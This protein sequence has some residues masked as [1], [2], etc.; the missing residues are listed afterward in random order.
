MELKRRL[1]KTQ[2]IPEDDAWVRTHC[3]M[4]LNWCGTLV[5]RQKGNVI[6]IEGDPDNP[7]NR[8]KICAKGNSAF[9]QLYIPDRIITPLIRKNPEKGA[10][11][12][13][14]FEPIGWDDALDLIASK[15][16]KIRS[17]NPRKL[18][19]TS[20]D[21]PSMDFYVAWAQGFGSVAKPMAAD[22]FCGNAVHNIHLTNET[23]F[24]ADPDPEL[25]KYF[26]LVGAQFGSVS[27]YDVMNAVRGI[28]ER[29]PS[30]VKVV[31]VDP[32]AGYAGSKAEEWVPIRPGTDCAFLLSVTNLLVNDYNIYDANFLKRQTNAPYLI[33]K[34]GAY[35]RDN[36]TQKPLVW[37]SSQNQAVAFDTTKDDLALLGTYETEGIECQPAFQKLKDHLRKYSAEYSSEITTIPAETIKRIA[38]EFGENAS[39]GSTLS[40]GGVEMPYRPVC[41]AWYRG[42]SSHRHSMMGGMAAENLNVIVGAI[43]VPGG[44]VGSGRIP[45][46]VTIDGLM[47]PAGGIYPGA[48]PPR[49]VTLPQTPD[50]FS[51]FPVSS[52]SSSLNYLGCLQPEVYKIPFTYEMLIVLRTNIMKT[53]A[54]LSIVEQFMR[55]IPFTLAFARRIEETTGMAD[56]VL[57]DLHYLE[58]ISFGLWFRTGPIVRS[59]MIGYDHWYGQK[60]VVRAPMNS[61]WGDKFV[62]LDQVLLELARRADFLPD[63]YRALNRMWRLKEPYI[64]DPDAEYTFEEMVDRCLK[65]LLGEERGYKWFMT[66]GLYLRPRNPQE[67]Y[68]GPFKTGR[69]H[70]YYEGMKKAGEDVKQ[71]TESAKIPWDTSDYQPLPDWKPCP[72]YDKEKKGDFDMYLLNHRIPQHAF[73]HTQVNPMLSQLVEKHRDDYILINSETAARKGIS[74]EDKIIV[75][76][77]R[78]AKMTGTARLSELVHPEVLAT[79]G[80]SR[81]S[82]FQDMLI[83]DMDHIDNVTG[84]LDSCI[85]VRVGCSQKK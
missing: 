73:S 7:Q 52:F 11:V 21:V 62:S 34:D 18:Y 19:F 33:G 37:S 50:M 68:T 67:R 43:D 46:E 12:D 56:L 25:C 57:P 60:P 61:P 27:H 69:L 5:H 47:A 3:D 42:I 49:K 66:D 38:K 13:P 36:A 29:R 35:V 78:G 14:K 71:V 15:L 59:G 28:A 1:Q 22:T 32:I 8:G 75:E 54:P 63:V 70:L 85:R 4:C 80:N 45:Y 30:A 26:L 20:F 76:N 83:Y 53:T 74:N 48:Y 82:N 84:S 40:V 39:I 64:L 44:Q 6:K 72:S 65:N 9:L 51:L 31:V 23:A 79:Q 16:K 81:R 58:R 10:L 17:D 77:T 55:K 41:V 2:T 24:E